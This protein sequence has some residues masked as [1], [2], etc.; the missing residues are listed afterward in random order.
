MAALCADFSSCAE[1]GTDWR[2]MNPS[3][4]ESALQILDAVTPRFPVHTI[5]DTGKSPRE[6]EGGSKVETGNCDVC[7]EF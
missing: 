2:R 3:M 4:H 6:C 5:T 7:C 1:V